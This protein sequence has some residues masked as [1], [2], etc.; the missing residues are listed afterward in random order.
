MTGASPVTTLHAPAKALRSR[1]VVPL[2]WQESLGA[3]SHVRLAGTLSGEQVIMPLDLVRKNLTLTRR[4]SYLLMTQSPVCYTHL[5]RY[6]KRR[7]KRWCS[8]KIIDMDILSEYN[9]AY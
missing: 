1:V 6:G 9:H 2:A 7:W 4:Q 5:G 8:E 3:L